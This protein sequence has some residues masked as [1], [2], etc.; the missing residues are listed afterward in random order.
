MHS[1]GLASPGGPG[2]ARKITAVFRTLFQEGSKMRGRYPSGPE[3]IDH[4]AGSD[5]AKR[6]ARV[7]LETI[8]GTCRVQEACARLE[9]SEPRF[10]QLRIHGL[11]H[12]I[13]S[14]EPRAAGRPPRMTSAAEERVR[15]LEDKIADLQMQVK[16]AQARAEIAL[17][18]PN[19]VQDG[20]HD[21][22]DSEVTANEVAPTGTPSPNEAQEKKTRRRQRRP[23]KPDRPRQRA[24][25]SRKAT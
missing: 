15:Q 19:A 5:V 6:R 24:P 13:A 7:L 1:V 3:F 23:Q 8:A 9:I 20:V 12:L 22:S 17:V 18:L 21:V 16:I 11:D 25:A 10:D 4:L 14:M 2:R